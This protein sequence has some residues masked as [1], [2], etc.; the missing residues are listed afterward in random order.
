MSSPTLIIE[1]D[2][3][4]TKATLDCDTAERQS[5]RRE[6]DRARAIVPRD[7]WL[8]TS[9]DSRKDRFFIDRPDG[10]RLFG[11]RFDKDPRDGASVTVE[12]VS[13]E[14]DAQDAKPTGGNRQF[15]NA[16][17]DTVVQD[18]IDNV[19]TL[20]AGTIAQLASNL[21]YNFPNSARS[22]QIRKVAVT[23]GGEVRYNADRTVDYVD[24]VGS[25]LSLT[26]SPSNQNIVGDI[27]VERDVRDEV[28]HVRAY[29]ATFNQGGEEQRTAEAVA[30]GYSG[31]RK[32]WREFEDT[33]IQDSG[34][35]QQIAD[36]LVS[37]YDGEPR[38]ITVKATIINETVQL[39]D[40]VTVK[41]PDHSID[42][43]LRITELTERFGEQGHEYIVTLQNRTVDDDI[44]GNSR[45]SLQRFNRG[46]QGFVDRDQVASGWD[47]AG[48]GTPQ[49]LEVVNYPDDI[50]T[51]KTVDLVI[52][53]RAWRS[54][55]DVSGHTHDVSI[56]TETSG[57][58][59]P[60]QLGQPSTEATFADQTINNGDYASASGTLDS[61]ASADQWTKQIRIQ[62]NWSDVQGGDRWR[63]WFDDKGSNVVEASYP[64]IVSDRPTSRTFDDD[65]NLW[66]TQINLDGG[67]DF[68]VR[69]YNE[70]GGSRDITDS[71]IVIFDLF[72]HSHTVDIGTVTS[73]SE[74]DLDASVIDT[75]NSNQFYP[76]DVDID[77]NGSTITTLSGNGS[78]DWQE[79]VDLS[80]KLSA[81]NNT[82]SADPTGGR[83][84]LNL[85]LQ[86][87]LFRRGPK[88]N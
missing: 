41:L 26:I 44:K 9:Y 53:G 64:V 78:G 84:E 33:D 14:R 58:Q 2:G 42:R 71:R 49:T 59:D 70:T 38:L 32:V 83:G 66:L 81:G 67:E 57:A 86:T 6:M 60:P 28:T 50:Q 73:D 87:E 4:N 85:I 18:A 43:Q 79:T 37:E 7:A 30:S 1:D 63:V 39:G 23:A 45:E 40:R 24:R 22:K 3:G 29:G 54:P 25:D 52:Q 16:D 27:T 69:L 10:T 36:R 17:D 76:T 82:I 65:L 68:E 47:P 13:F 12:I 8:S 61:S 77:V 62:C 19:P 34:R 55:V 56:G 74:S 20:S 88:S 46:Y 75:F 15:L 31:G 51:E 48:D 5:V 80:G 11:G 21:T 35:L 72:K